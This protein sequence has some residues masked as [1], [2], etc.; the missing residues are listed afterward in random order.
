MRVVRCQ[1]IRTVGSSFEELIF[2]LGAVPGCRH[3]P[4]PPARFFASRQQKA[5]F[6]RDAFGSSAWIVGAKQQC[7]ITRRSYE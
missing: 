4:Q 5:D 6:S 1:D 7:D 2:T 3:N